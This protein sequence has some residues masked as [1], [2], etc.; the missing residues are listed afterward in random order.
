MNHYSL[1][2]PQRISDSRPDNLCGGDD[3]ADDGQH[4]VDEEEEGEREAAV[5]LL[6]ATVVEFHLSQMLVEG[7]HPD[8][9][10]VM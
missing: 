10:L 6:R 3:G 1:L 2:I 7:H 5:H 9:C 4:Q 8:Q